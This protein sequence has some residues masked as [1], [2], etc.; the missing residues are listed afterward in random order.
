MV[1]KSRTRCRYE[2]SDILQI[3]LYIKFRDM[4]I[5]YILGASSSGACEW[6]EE[7]SLNACICLKCRLEEVPMYSAPMSPENVHFWMYGPH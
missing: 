6:I 2:N 7:L 3:N 1:L 5:I 4:L